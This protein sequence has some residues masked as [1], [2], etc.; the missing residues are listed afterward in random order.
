MNVTQVLPRDA[1]PSVD[2]PTFTDTY[3]GDGDDEMIVLDGDPP[4]AYPVRYLHFHEI[5]NDTVP[6]LQAIDDDD[7]PKALPVAVTW[8]P[9][10]GSA[11]AYDRRI[12]G[13]DEPVEF[14]VSGKLADDDLVMYDRTTETEWKQSTGEAIAGELAGRSLDPVPVSIQSYDRFRESAP[15]GL[16]L[17]QPGGKSEAAGPGDDPE[18]VDYDD[19]P[20]VEYF[21]QDGFGLDAHRGGE[22]R[23]WDRDDLDPKTVVLGIEH[24]EDALGIPVPRL[25]AAGG[26]AAVSVGGQSILAVGTDDGLFGYEAPS[27]EVRQVDDPDRFE[28]DGTRWNARTGTGDD[29]RTLDRI[30][31][32]RL[33]A[34]TWQDDH[35]PESFW[36]P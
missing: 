26:V 8:C 31:I 27:G 11:V 36:N 15:D 9:L 16:V 33:F 24:N 17:Q 3:D 10:C 4:R 14:G 20:Y 7:P 6:G 30:P 34:F 23:S 28:A 12:D 25:K 2:D 19:R 29:G 18:P 32:R 13:V 35:G 22:G 1:I 5:V 21:E